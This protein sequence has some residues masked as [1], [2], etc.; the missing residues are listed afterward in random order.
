M[1][2]KSDDK[3]SKIALAKK[4]VD[5]ELEQRLKEAKEKTDKEL[6]KQGGCEE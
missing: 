2:K 1:S 6:E 5:P 3:N 4:S